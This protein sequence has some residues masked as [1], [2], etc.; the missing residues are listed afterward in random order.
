LLLLCSP[1]LA[2]D[3]ALGSL[4]RA[5][6]RMVKGVNRQSSRR[7]MVSGQAQGLVL[8]DLVKLRLACAA[9]ERNGVASQWEAKWWLWQLY[10]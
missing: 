3:P 7:P 6:I 2:C 4:D 5:S 1:L 10:P 8:A 9:D